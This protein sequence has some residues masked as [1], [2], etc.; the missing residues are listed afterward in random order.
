MPIPLFKKP[1]DPK[2]KDTRL[3]CE[4][5]MAKKSVSMVFTRFLAWSRWSEDNSLTRA[6]KE[7]EITFTAATSRHASHRCGH[8][9]CLIHTIFE[10]KPENKERDLCQARARQLRRDGQEVQNFVPCIRNSRATC[11]FKRLQQVR[12]STFKC[13]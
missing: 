1:S 2:R 8:G 5:R 11:N 4:F 10:S 9:N 12:F 3:P 6:E 7:A 13:R